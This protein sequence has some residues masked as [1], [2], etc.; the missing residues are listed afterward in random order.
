MKNYT[1]SSKRDAKVLLFYLQCVDFL[2]NFLI[3]C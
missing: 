1:P 3:K 2:N